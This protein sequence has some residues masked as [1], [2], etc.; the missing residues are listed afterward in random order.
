MRQHRSG[1]DVH[2]ERGEGGRFDAVIVAT[3]ANQ[4]A[5][6]DDEGFGAER[7]LLRGIPYARGEL[8]VHR[9]QRFMP[10]HRRDWSALNF[11]VDATTQRPMFTVW[12]NAVEPTLK[13]KPPVFQTWN[14]CFDPQPDLTLARQP[15]Q[16]AVVNRGTQGILK[17]L[18]T[19]HRQPGRRLFYCGSWAHQGV[20]LLETAVRSAQAVVRRIKA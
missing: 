8:V 4:L 20:P 19:W 11:Q 15:L 17:A 9:D 12:V 16:R 14:P 13:D 18:N 5:F 1:I 3:Q 7:E 10:R 6:L 2:N